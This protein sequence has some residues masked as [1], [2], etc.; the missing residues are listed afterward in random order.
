MAKSY[1]APLAPASDWDTAVDKDQD[2]DVNAVGSANIGI[3]DVHLLLNSPAG[4]VTPLSQNTH[5]LELT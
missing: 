1:K 2:D 4:K 3:V 5:M